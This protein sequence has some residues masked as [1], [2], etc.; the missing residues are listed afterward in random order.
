MPA[1]LLRTAVALGSSLGD[2]DAHLRYAVARLRL[3]LTDL[4]VSEFVD[5]APCGG[6]GGAGPRFLNGAAVGWSAAE[7]AA[8]LARLHAI[9]DARGRRRPFPNAPRTLDLDLVL[10]GGLVVSTPALTLPH[11]RF[12][13]RRFVLEPLAA[14]APE[15]VDPVTGLSVRALL[16]RLGQPV[17]KPRVAPRRASRPADKA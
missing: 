14:V 3:L 16:A 5:T 17:V 4:A 10:M 13:A 11:P 8:L 6:G 12:R 9:E 7:P 2:R 1:R 15:L